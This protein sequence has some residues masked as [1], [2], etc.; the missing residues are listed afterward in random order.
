MY[1]LS[2][3]SGPAGGGGGS[4]AD[5]SLQTVY[6][7][8]WQE[9][10]WTIG[11]EE[12]FFFLVLLLVSSKQVEAAGHMTGLNCKLSKTQKMNQITKTPD[13]SHDIKEEITFL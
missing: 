5:K 10:K 4:P 3:K 9:R 1:T 2:I 8:Y 7:K 11:E 6:I 12:F 13:L